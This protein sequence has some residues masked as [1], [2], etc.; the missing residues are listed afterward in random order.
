ME[1]YEVSEVNYLN[2]LGHSFGGQYYSLL[3]GSFL[4]LQPQFGPWPTFMKLS[5][6]LPF[7]R[8]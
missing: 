1:Q 7:T 4:A 8:S 5:F 6:S 3:Q 2:G